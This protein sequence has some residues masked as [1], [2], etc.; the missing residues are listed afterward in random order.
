MKRALSP[1]MTMALHDIKQHGGRLVRLPGGYWTYPDCPRQS[2]DGV[3]SW[4][5][6][7]STVLALVSR[8]RLTYCEWKEGRR[9]TFPVAA[10]LP[11]L[12]ATA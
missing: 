12:Q 6:G 7:S 8:Q 4:Y 10:C 2:H 3:P 1:T 11:E 9:C 5:L